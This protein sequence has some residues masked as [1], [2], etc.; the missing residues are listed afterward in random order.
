MDGLL[1]VCVGDELVVTC[2]VNSFQ[3]FFEVNGKS[4]GFTILSAVNSTEMV[5]GFE[6]MLVSTGQEL[7]STAT[8]NNI[9]PNHNGT[10][11][12]CLTAIDVDLP[13]EEMAN[14]TIIVQGIKLTH[15]SLTTMSHLLSA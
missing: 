10:V 15:A 6:I 7:V 2:T 13:P 3:I 1:D 14:I 4:I 8:I 5:G 9:N 11:L 12:T